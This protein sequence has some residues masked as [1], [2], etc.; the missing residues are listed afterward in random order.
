MSFKELFEAF[1]DPARLK[2]IDLLQEEDMTPSQ[3]AE[4]LGLSKP[5]ISHHLNILKRAGVVDSYKRGKNVYYTL[6]I[7]IFEEI[8]RFAMKYTG[9]GGEK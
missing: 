4:K 2:I 6:E 7:S 3:L 9:K 5:T 8:I 1:A